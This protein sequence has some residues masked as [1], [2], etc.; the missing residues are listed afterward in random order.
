MTTPPS[1]TPGTPG[2]P[3][4]GDDLADT[5]HTPNSGS[6]PSYNDYTSSNGGGNQDAADTLSPGAGLYPGAGA[7]LG[8]YIIDIIIVSVVSMLVSAPFV[9]FGSAGVSVGTTATVSLISIVLWFVYRIGMETGTGATLGKMALG[10][11][12]VDSNGAKLDIQASFMRNLWFLV[13]N[14]ASIVPFVGFLLS[15]A[16]YITLGVTISRDPYK[17]SFADKWGKAYVVRSR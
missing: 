2:N 12:V 16:V 8:A 5:D 4:D 10:L 13:S 14:L 11:K 7:R 3:F 17:Q 9:D 6:L 15:L 1:G